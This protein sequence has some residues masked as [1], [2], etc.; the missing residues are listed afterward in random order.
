[1]AAMDSR[2]PTLFGLA[3]DAETVEMER[4][5]PAD[6]D[7]R[8]DAIDVSRSVL[9]QAPAGAGKTNLLTQRYLALLAQVEEPEQVLAITF[10]RAATAEMHSRIVSTLE[11]A[12]RCPEPELGEGTEMPLARA[13]LR[14]ADAL[15]W[16]LL[17]QPHR[18]DVQTIDS[19]CMRFAHAQPLLARL[20][21]ALQPADDAASLYTEAA[22]RTTALLHSAD[23]ESAEALRT[24]L[25]RR[26]NNLQEVERLLADMLKQRDAWLGVLPLAPSEHVDWAEVRSTLEA[27]FA[28]ESQRVLR[29]LAATVE[30]MPDS[31]EE[32][33][34]VARYAAS[35]PDLDGPLPH[36]TAALLDMQTLPGSEQE[37]YEAWLA[38]GCLL[39]TKEGTWKKSW[40]KRDGFPPKEKGA[41]NDDREQWKRRVKEL[42]AELQAH[43]RGPHLLQLLCQVRGL[44]QRRYSDD[45]WHTL[46]AIFRLLRRAAAELR[47]VFAAANQVDFIEI[48][49]A[50]EA[51]LQ[52]EG[53]LRGMLESD[54][55]RHILIDEFQDT[56]RAQHRLIAALLREWD[57]GDG[58]TLFLVGDP[59]Q[60]IY[61][62][63]EAEVAL[64]HRTRR[65]GLPCG[66]ASSPRYHR[67]HPLTLTHNFRSHRALVDALNARLQPV[68]AGASAED[69]AAFVPATAWERTVSEASLQLH[70]QV[71]EPAIQSGEPFAAGTVSFTPSRDAE[72][73]DIV[74][75]LEHELPSAC[76]AQARGEHEY[77]IAIL[78]RARRDLAAILPALRAA[79]IPFRAVDLEPLA[80]QPE[81]IDLL[82]LLRALLHP[83]D[84]L[85]WLGVLRAPWC[86]LLLHD[87]H[88]LSGSDDPLL[89][90]RSIAELLT[91]R[92]ALLSADGQARAGRTWTTLRAALETRYSS[93]SLSLSAWLERT[94]WALG[95]D[96]CVDATARENVE[97]FFRL[98]DSVAPNGSEVLRTDFPQR[99][100][101]LCAAPDARTNERFGV[102]IMTIHKAKG[103]GFDVV[104]LPGLDRKTGGQG[105][106]LLAMV[107]RARPGDL[108]VD[109]LLLAPLGN[110]DDSADAAYRWVRSQ[111][112]VR[113]REEAR[114]LFYV[115]A[116]RARTRLHL[117]ATLKEKDGEVVRPGDG[118]LLGAAWAG[119]EADVRAAYPAQQ[120][121]PLRIAASAEVAS[122]TPA[123]TYAI[124]RL[125]AGWTRTG[126][127]VV[128]AKA[129]LPRH[130]GQS[131]QPEA[132]FTRTESG[133][134]RAR[135]QGTAMHALMERLAVLFARHPGAPT[136][137]VAGWRVHLLRVAG[138]SLRASAVPVEEA[139]KAAAA[140]A[141][142]ALAVASD[143]TGRW[144]LAPHAQAHTESSRQ[145][146]DETGTLRTVRIDRS[147]FAGSKPGAPG[148]DTFWIIDYKTGMDRDQLPGDTSVDTWLDYQRELYR[149]Q[150]A[151]YARFLSG[152]AGARTIHCAL[153]FPELLRLVDWP[154][155]NS[156]TTRQ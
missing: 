32:L 8:R 37:D 120:R 48:A 15:G 68:F 46:L 26:D 90:R 154:A 101:K 89:L 138:Q 9:V 149:D 95:G 23:S 38:F 134:L 65:F 24:I 36:P 4:P 7:A 129:A 55:K 16:S 148:E 92:L 85:S 64:F 102:Q 91:T 128:T 108:E 45:Q 126:D 127:P 116:T 140:L 125:P 142:Y 67:C 28:A 94:W 11:A 153:Y 104:L 86:G 40:T 6:S 137:V 62:F 57:D 52:A 21:G 84:R 100:A 39:L 123:A 12:R 5:A 139:R 61:L 135:A 63:R 117:F 71:A 59:L 146:W 56:S 41:R 77:R 132:L 151:T 87:L 79:G 3:D 88:I 80:E 51:V 14:H 143:E 105:S 22:R 133:S 74:R 110:K 43:L 136:A 99:L 1:M 27:P 42:S 66:D 33:L 130:G 2:Q 17:E 72:A 119:L 49:Q 103:L 34:A 131:G 150:L 111:Q 109:E 93:G 58:R 50:A 53:S 44:P 114:R 98:L 78:V 106:D 54:R 122:V 107:Q 96:A 112:L 75:V 35:H 19:L 155:G 70:L 31:V 113:E 144:L 115:A 18:L 60:S 156:E 73:A 152:S 29:E 25:L 47:L 97:Q 81:I 121:S 118:S 147:F 10:T 145:Q 82:S 30:S 76:E 13:A 20:G 124:E 69:A 141:E 83:A